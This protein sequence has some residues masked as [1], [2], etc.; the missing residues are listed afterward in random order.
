MYVPLVPPISGRIVER[1]TAREK[2]QEGNKKMPLDPLQREALTSHPSLTIKE[3]DDELHKE[4]I[5]VMD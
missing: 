4:V 1:R 3:S 5:D 2:H